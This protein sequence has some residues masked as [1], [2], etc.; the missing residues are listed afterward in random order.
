MAT[1]KPIN[2]TFEQTTDSWG[3]EN[4]ERGIF[5]DNRP[6]LHQYWYLTYGTSG[7]DH[8]YG[9]NYFT[10]PAGFKIDSLFE[11]GKVFHSSNEIISDVIGYF[12]AEHK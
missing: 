10:Y 9:D 3:F 12:I 5:S 11:D 6:F 2:Y 8:E 7:R 1:F 4:V